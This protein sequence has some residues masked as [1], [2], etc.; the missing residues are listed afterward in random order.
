MRDDLLTPAPEESFLRRTLEILGRRKMVAALAFATVLASALSFAR[1]LPDLFDASAVVLVERQ[2]PETYVKTAVSDELE[3]RLHVIKQEVLSRTRLTELVQRFDLYPELR[4]RNDMEAVLEQM[5]HDIRITPTGP[6]QVNGRTRTVAFDLT[7]AGTDRQSVAEVTNAIAS[8]Y[9]DQNNQMRSDEAARTTQFLKTQL[10]DARTQLSANEQRVK[11]YTSRY[12][13]QLPQQVEVNLATLERL[14]TQL[15]LNGERQLRTLEQRE[16]IAVVLPAPMATLPAIAPESPNSERLEKAQADLNEVRAKFTDNHP[17]VKRVKE[18]I[19]VIE[20]QETQRLAGE[21][22]AASARTPTPPDAPVAPAARAGSRTIDSLDSELERLKGDEAT[23][24]QGIASV[25]GRLESV[26]YR[27]NE[28]ALISRDHQAVKDLY[29]SLL[30]RYEEAQLAASMESENQG[31]RF[32]ILEAAIP[33]TA[34][35]APNRPRLLVIGLLLAILV[36]GVAV[37]ILEQLDTSFHSVGDLRAFTNVPVLVT[38]PRIGPAPSR[39]WLKAT[40]ATA[41]VAVVL[42]V[43]VTLS[44]YLAQGNEQI[45]RLLVRAG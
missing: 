32:R 12:V 43:I 25:E 21:K 29:D 20:A 4:A 40:V 17:D 14:N 28:F 15:R 9:V 24:R 31:E 22:A 41:S 3:S 1:Y 26:P 10:D 8:F 7:Y 37:L 30:K 5:R 19:A 33:P 44:A 42:I 27:Q 18:E 38:I 16:K 35:S 11:D 2:L 45:V 13:G 34:P 36:A 6:E 23:L 39:Y